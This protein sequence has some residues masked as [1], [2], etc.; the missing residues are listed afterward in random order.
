M[1]GLIIFD[2]PALPEGEDMAYLHQREEFLV[3]SDGFTGIWERNPT[4]LD[5]EDVDHQGRHAKSETAFG[6]ALQMLNI[7]AQKGRLEHYLEKVHRHGALGPYGTYVEYEQKVIA[8]LEKN[9]AVVLPEHVLCDSPDSVPVEEIDRPSLAAQ[10][11]AADPDPE[12]SICLSF[13]MDDVPEIID[14]TNQQCMSGDEQLPTSK[15]K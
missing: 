8:D 11:E 7:E 1:E 13:G 15:G 12:Y 2:P 5:S 4:P 9:A 3:P 6:R 14:E 10:P